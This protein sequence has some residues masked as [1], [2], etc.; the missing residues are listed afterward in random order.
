VQRLFTIEGQAMNTAATRLLGIGLLLLL[1]ATAG[2]ADAAD[3]IGFIYVGPAADYGYNMSMDLGRQHVEKRVPNVT[4]SAFEQIPESAE[5]ER[6]MER[7]ISTGHTIIFATS[8]GYLDRAIRVGQRYPKVTFLH[9]GGLKTAPNVGTYWADSDDGMYL[10]GMVAGA[11]TKTGKLG[12]VGAFQ[13]P[14][15]FRS[16]N[17]FT[18][19]AQA[20][21]PKVTMTVVWTGGW[22][23]P[24]KEAEAVN[25]FADQGIDVIAEQVDSPI[26]IAQTAEKRGVYIVGKDVDVK[27]RAPRAWLTGVSWN[28]GPMMARLVEEV[29]AGTWKPGHVRGNLKSGDA[30]LDPFGASVPEAVRKRVLAVKDEILSGK[31]VVWQGPIVRQDGKPAVGPGQK[32]TLEQIETMDYLVK[33][34]IGSTK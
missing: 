15:L 24:Q 33:G 29:R 32:M 25:A 22:W 9:A 1:A 19:G 23:E 11:V 7:L 28:W 13:I 20:V 4:T 27:D 6:V 18:L 31:K 30:V 8:Y 10:A 17:A 16:I 5:V 26:T 14:Q 2:R 3:K 21:N 34:V 12:F